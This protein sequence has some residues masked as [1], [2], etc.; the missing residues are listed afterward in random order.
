MVEVR[1]EGIT[2][3]YGRK[4]ALSDINIRVRHNTLACFLGPSGSGKTTL[5]R[6]IA[7]LIK[8]TRGRVFF[9]NMDVTNVPAWKRNV[10]FVPQNV[11]LFPHLS[12][13]ENI[14]FGLR[15]K[16]VPREEMDSRIKAM[17][18]LIKLEG[19]ENRKPTELSGGEAQRVAIAR[20]LVINPSVLLFDEPLGHLD[21]KLRDELKFEIRR[22][23][24][25]TGTTGIYVT[26]D[27]AE[28]FAIADYIYVINDGRIEQEGAPHELYENPQSPFIADFIGSV[29]F[30]RG[31]IA[32]FS[33]DSMHAKIRSRNLEIIAK[34]PEKIAPGKEVLVGIRPEHIKV[35][36]KPPLVTQEKI[37]NGIVTRKVFLGPSLILEIETGGHMLKAVLYGDEKYKFLDVNIG[38]EIYFTLDR[39]FVFTR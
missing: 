1:T 22:I 37:Y 30:L 3:V 6:I 27:Q 14:A 20:A 36:L 23:Q 13:Y 32:D 17:L 10:G 26:H 35:M 15:A 19:Y 28:A 11:A 31:I 39:A 7:G 18:R 12:V 34:I 8:P 33:P 5:L 25:E 38:T 2:K 29:N 21:A 16:R 24:R 4:V 9:D